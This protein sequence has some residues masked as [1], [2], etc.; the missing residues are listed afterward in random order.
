[1]NFCYLFCLELWNY[2]TFVVEVLYNAIL[3][4]MKENITPVVNGI[5]SAPLEKTPSVNNGKCLPAL[6]YFLAR[7]YERTGRAV[8]VTTVSAWVR[9][10]KSLCFGLPGRA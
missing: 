6:L 3:S 8:A 10:K 4:E 2:S 1:M 9:P 7:L 5:K